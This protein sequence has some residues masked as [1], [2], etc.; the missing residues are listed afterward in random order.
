MD[1]K[2]G[3]RSGERGAESKGQGAGSREQG[4]GRTEKEKRK[5]V[6]DQWSVELI[7]VIA[8]VK[9]GVLVPWWQKWYW[10]FVIRN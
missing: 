10:S 6:G 5:V 3:K 2:E 1:I 4:A 9:L 7:Y 8:L